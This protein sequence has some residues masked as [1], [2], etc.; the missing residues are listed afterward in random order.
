MAAATQAPLSDFYNNVRELAFAIPWAGVPSATF[1]AATAYVITGVSTAAAGV[2]FGGA[3]AIM[4]GTMLLINMIVQ[5]FFL[6]K[7]NNLY[8]AIGFL[9]SV[10]TAPIGGWAACA[11][12]GFALTALQITALTVSSYVGGFLGLYLNEFLFN[13]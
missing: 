11:A 5:T 4:F 2:L 6:S 1:G 8:H 13:S 7:N 12:A 9:I 3:A 10:L